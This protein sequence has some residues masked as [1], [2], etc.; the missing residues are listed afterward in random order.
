MKPEKWIAA[1]FKA[2][3][4]GDVLAVERLVGKGAQMDVRESLRE[5]EYGR[6]PLSVAADHGRAGVVKLLIGLGADIESTD[7]GG[8]RALHGAA[9]NDS[10]E[11]AEILMDAGARV[12]ASNDE[13]WQ[14]LHYAAHYGYAGMAKLLIA[15]DAKIEAANGM[16]DHPLHMAVL[17]GHGET[18]RVL[19]A[20]GADVN[21]GGMWNRRPLHLAA[22]GR[23]REV[24][25]LLLACGA[26]P[27]LRDRRKQLPRAMSLNEEMTGLLQEAEKAWKGRE[28]LAALRARHRKLA[29]LRPPA[30]SL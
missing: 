25:E 5:S 7:S 15:R 23:S 3:R 4:D 24:L 13:G 30:P 29:S 20:N 6:Q 17:G 28:A 21:A 12:D 9:A 19:I 22:E 14:P 26:N 8:S 16:G 10:T 1:L 11:V 27:M 2:V 18:V